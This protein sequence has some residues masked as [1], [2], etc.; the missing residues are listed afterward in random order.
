ML[1]SSA[2]RSA[3]LVMLAMV[4]PVPGVLAGDILRGG[5]T[6]G[7]AAQRA[8][9]EA[10]NRA[11]DAA[12]AAV[13]QRANDRLA[14]TTR[15]ITVMEGAQTAARAA[16]TV[17]SS[18][19]PDGLAEGGLKVLTGPHAR[20]TGANAPVQ[21]ASDE[22]VTVN[23]E[24]TL[25]QAILHWETFNVGRRTLLNFDQSKGGADA[26][27]WTVLNKVF[28]PKGRVTEIYGRIQGQGQ[29]HM[30]NRTGF[31]FRPGSGVEAR[32]I[33][34]SSLP[35]NGRLVERGLV[36]QDPKSVQFL[37]SEL[38][39]DAFDRDLDLI[40]DGQIIEGTDYLASIPSGDVTIEAG[41]RLA[42]RT[43]A[44]KV[45]GRVTLVGANVR[46]SGTIATPDGQTI[47]A[48]G[49]QVG[50][51]A[52]PTTDPTLRGLDVYIG[53]AD[54]TVG[55]A[56][57]EGMIEA[58]RANVTMAGRK[59]R[60]LGVI[61]SSTTTALNGR[62]DLL[63][64][65]NA[66]PY[67]EA[68]GSDFPSDQATTTPLFYSGQSGL[69]EI[70]A[71]SLIAILPE[72]GGTDRA[73][74]T[75]LALGS[76]VNMQ[77]RAIHLGRGSVIHAS[78][79]SLPSGKTMAVDGSRDVGSSS[80]LAGVTA[81][82]GN[83][84][85]TA[86]EKTRWAN[87]D[88]E[89][90]SAEQNYVGG[91]IFFDKGS[92][93]DVAGSVDVHVPLS[94]LLLN[95]QLRG[96]ELANAPL[97]RDGALRGT[98]ITV[99]L[100]R[101]GVFNG[102]F[103]LGTPL[104]D[105]AGYAAIIERNVGQLTVAGGSVGL[106][107]GEAV[108]IQKGSLID[109][110]GG[111][112]QVA[113]GKVALTRLLS[114]G[115][116]VDIGDA[117]P[118]RVYEGIYT[119]LTTAVSTKWGVSKTYRNALAPTGEYYQRPYVEGGDAG[120]I[121]ITAAS[122]ALDGEFK[123]QAVQGHR[124][125][126]PSERAFGTTAAI[127]RGGSLTIN[128]RNETLFSD[129]LVPQSPTP[130]TIVL[131]TKSALPA[132]EDF[133]FDD[134]GVV[135]PLA[136]ERK[137]RLILSPDILGNSGFASLAVDNSDGDI[138]VPVGSA[139]TTAPLG[140]I[141]LS[142]ANITIGASITAPGGDL[143][144]TVHNFSPHE[145][146]KL[147]GTGLEPPTPEPD[148]ERGTFNLA[149]GTVLSTAG[150]I[151]DRRPGF[152]PFRILDPSIPNGGSISINAY[153]ARLM[154]GSVIDASGG[155]TVNSSG[156][157]FYGS[158]GNI[159]IAAGRD[160]SMTWLLGG[161][162]TLLSTL[163]SY[164][165]GRLAGI[166]AGGNAIFPGENRFR[167]YM[168]GFRWEAKGGSLSITAPMIQIGGKRPEGLK[169][170]EHLQLA[171][172]FF[173]KGGF[174]SYSLTGLG[175]PIDAG[176]N[177]FRPGIV[178]SSGTVLEPRAESWRA[179]IS[180]GRTSLQPFRRDEVS[181]VPVSISFNSPVIRDRWDPS[182]PLLS[183]GD[184]TMGA[185]AR[186]ENQ[187]TASVGFSGGTVA[188]LGSVIAPGGSISVRG[189]DSF[190]L[191]SQSDLTAALP[192]VN[193][194]PHSLLSAAGT[195]MRLPDPFGRR[196]GVVLP[197]G[198]ITVAGNVVAEA[199]AVLDVSGASD[200]V[201][202]HPWLL[203]KN[204]LAFGGMA[205]RVPASSGLTTQ[206]FFTT[207]EAVR[208]DSDA[209][210]IAL[211]GSQE[212][213][214]DANLRGFAGGPTA[215]G[216]TLVVSSGRFV[217]V[218]SGASASPL[219]INLIVTETGR[220][221]PEGFYPDGQTAIGNIVPT[222]DGT[223]DLGRGRFAIA[224]FRRGGF[225]ALK[226]CGT[227]QGAVAF[228][229]EISVSA[230]RS[231]DIAEG[232]VLFADSI[233]R[234]SAPYVSLGSVFQTPAQIA[235]AEA[236]SLSLPGN[237]Y[238]TPTSGSGELVVKAA[239]IDIGNLS[240]QGISTASFFAPGGDIRGNGS[241]NVAGTINLA[242]GQIYPTSANIFTIA[243]YDPE[244][245]PDGGTINIAAA[246]KSAPP[247]SAGGKLNLFA[248]NIVQGGT[249]QAPFGT[250]HLGWDGTGP[251]PKDYLSGAGL[252]EGFS[253]PIT[254][255]LTL[256]PE[257]VTSVS[258]KGLVV[259]YGFS[260]DGSSWIDPTGV[261][262][263]ATGPPV[264]A[265][266]L[267]SLN[268]NLQQGSLVDVSGGGEL[269][270]YRWVQG[271]DGAHDLLGSPTADWS[272]STSYE[273]GQ[274][275]LHEGAIWSARRPNQGA[276]PSISLDWT[277]LPGGFAVLPSYSANVAP[278]ASFNNRT[279]ELNLAR[280]EPGY[281]SRGL[282]V[283]DRVYLS[284]G[285]GLA[286]GFYTLLPTRYALLPGG[287]FV[288]PRQTSLAGSIVT[289]EG[290]G[291]VSGYRFNGYPRAQAPA[292]FEKFE[293]VP[294]NTLDKRVRYDDFLASDFFAGSASR[295]GVT[296]PRLPQD[297]GR[298]LVSG[299]DSLELRGFIQGRGAAG[300]YGAEID[301]NSLMPI[302]VV[303]RN[304]SAAHGSVRLDG[305]LISSFGANSIL[306]GGTRE[307]TASGVRV[308]VNTPELSVE[309]G[310]LLKAPEVMLAAKGGLMLGEQV[311]IVQGGRVFGSA[312]GQRRPIL[313]GDETV[314]GSGNG[315]LLAVS[316]RQVA[317][318]R[319][320]VSSQAEQAGAVNAAQL[321]IG[322]GTRL[323]STAL[324][325]DSTH[326][327]RVDPS[328]DV[329]AQEV[330]LQAGSISLALDNPG[331]VPV[332]A[333]LM[334]DKTSLS[335]LQ[336]SGSITLLSYSSID[337][338]GSGLF[339][340][341]GSLALDAASIRG[342]NTG[343]GT[344]A[345]SAEEIVLRNTVGKKNTPTGAT[346][347]QLSFDASSLRLG[348]GDMSIENFARVVM[349]GGQ[350]LVAT[351]SGTLDI[352]GAISVV[353]P[354]VSVSS[355]SF[356]IKASGPAD[357]ARPPA[358]ASGTF[359]TGL[360]A[361]L[362]ITAESLAINTDIILPGGSVA[363]RATSGGVDFAN[364]S[365]ASI[366]V[367]G[368]ERILG[369][370]ARYADGGSVSLTADEGN[371]SIGPS[372]R[373]NVSAA[374]R[375]GNAGTVSI[376][377]PKGTLALGGV[378]SGQSG[379]G[380]RGGS[381]V[382]DVAEEKDITLIDLAL[383]NGGFNQ[384]RSYRIRNGDVAITG[385]AIAHSYSLFA[386]RGSV[387]IT[388]GGM[389][390]SAGRTG[391]SIRIGAGGSI[392]LENGSR[393]SARAD[394][395]DSAGKGGSISLEA[396]SQVGGL[397]DPN[398]KIEIQD[399]SSVDL[400]VA[401]LLAEPPAPGNFSGTLRLRA[402]YLG[403]TG[404]GVSPLRGSIT[405][406]S[407]VI[408]EGYSL[409]DI[410]AD[411]ILNQ[412]LLAA[413]K[414]TGDAFAA[415]LAASS[416]TF[417]GGLP[418]GSVLAFVPGVEIINRTGN[419][420]LGDANSTSASD[421]NLGS[422][423]FGPDSVPGNLTIRAAGDI[424]FFNS[425]SDG[426]T[427]GAHTAELLPRNPKLPDNLQSWSY[428][429][430]AGSDLQAADSRAIRSLDKL[431]LPDTGSIMI[432]K[433]YTENNG[434]PYAGNGLEARTSDLVGETYF[435]TIRTGSGN[436]DLA[437]GRDV[438]LLNQWATVYTAG[439]RIS[440]PTIGGRFE[441]PPVVSIGSDDGPLG[442]QQQDP[443]YA[444]QYSL[445]GGNVSILAQG[446]IKRQTMSGG[447]LVAD[448]QKQ[449][450]NNWLY[451]R[452]YID[453][454]TGS[455]GI[456]R[457][458][459][460]GS[461]TWWVDFSNFFQGVGALGGGNVLLA[462]GNDIANIDAV[463][464]TSGRVTYITESGDRTP[465]RQTLVET[466]GG[467]ITVRAGRDIDAGIYYVERG[468]GLL[469]AGR[470]I[471]TNPTRTAYGSLGF[472][473]DLGIAATSEQ[474]LPT[475]LFV[476]KGGFDVIAGGNLTL[477]PAVNA[478]LL[479][480][481]I[482][483]SFFRKT[484]F[485]SYSPDSYVRATSLGGDVTLRQNS[486]TTAFAEDVSIL[487]NWMEAIHQVTTSDALSLGQPWLRLGETL[488][489][490]FSGMLGLAPPTME[491]SSL[492]GD[493]NLA[494]RFTLSP[495][496]SGTVE[497]LAA[498]AVNGF[499]PRGS[500]VSEVS[501]DSA[502]TLWGNAWINLSDADPDSIPGILRPFAYQ[503]LF[504]TEPANVIE[505]A[506]G[507]LG[508]L[509]ELFL[510]SGSSE[511]IQASIQT[512]QKLHGRSLLHAASTEPMRIFAGSGDISGL[513]L[514]SPKAVQIK[515]GRDITDIAFYIQ[516]TK[517]ADTS[518]VSAKRDIVP[519]SPNS[520]ARTAA[521]AANGLVS[522]KSLDGDIQISGPGSLLVQAGG[523]LD[524]GT[525]AN[526]ADGTG[527][528]ITSVGNARNPNLP[529]KGA[530]LYLGAGLGVSEPDYKT[531][532]E[533]FVRGGEGQKY[534]AELAD[535]TGGEKFEDLD[536][537]KQRLVALQVFYLILRDAGREEQMGQG[538]TKGFEA[539][540]AL[541]PGANYSGDMLTRSRDVRTKSGGN[542]SI[543]VSGGGL[544][545]AT[546]TVGVPVLPP[547]IV[548]EAGGNI[549]IFANGNVDIGISRIFTL[550]GGNQ[551]IWSSAGDIAAGASSKTVQSAPPTRVLID[552]QT[553]ELKVDLGGLATGGG[554]G[555]LASVEGVEPG[556][557]D[558]IAPAGVVDA[559]DAGIRATGNL[560]IAATQ[561]LNADNISVGGSAAGVSTAPIVA[562]PN[563]SGLTA[564]ATA[565][566]ANNSAAQNMANQAD[567][568]ADH[569]GAP[570]IITVEVLGY[571][572]PSDRS[573][574]EDDEEVVGDRRSAS[575]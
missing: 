332:I 8:Q 422:L 117:T 412:S 346:A 497:L 303:P 93:V 126:R 245:S 72:L 305:D 462:A 220:F 153:T 139:L 30:I 295:L 115:N 194:G 96:A 555:V 310:A 510:E 275:A 244:D 82:A 463:A 258:G 31:V 159:S 503:A 472:G 288:S 494:G 358:P 429:V 413:I 359:A 448:S 109:V 488:L 511:G 119:G 83:W 216:G 449:I 70:G 571:G 447:V 536:L 121:V 361:K 438:Q 101:S 58:P 397:I 7:A 306:I 373:I 32:S 327:M 41:A 237:V 145:F 325:L 365:A 424:V 281:T 3:L 128:L 344:F 238:V 469:Q 61:A 339:S 250:I 556:S 59:V 73:I 243:A 336:R 318:V 567:P 308:Q 286:A 400:S 28:D 214:V 198:S 402:P 562:T 149:T 566:A 458:G 453:P 309:S 393:L 480:I 557:V 37:F 431:S 168:N 320:G 269:Y 477:G 111:T 374:P 498:R 75:K 253:L 363:L 206:P 43:S 433:I 17:R 527:V 108:I 376:I 227:A 219:D 2:P 146:N 542:I 546:T 38:E 541:F 99:D 317:V 524:L 123:G 120:S 35:I 473:T 271:N 390:D 516:N 10:R 179:V 478:F 249:L 66:K 89:L 209:G 9:A 366:E 570:S 474:W 299:L 260:T 190:P 484:Y 276:R 394:R 341:A 534:L 523:N 385:P 122:L 415:N 107:A 468:R 504:G 398:A 196:A 263:T 197:G 549:G 213:F 403:G 568:T 457:D 268:L 221:L 85:K 19:I 475:T 489:R 151:T 533:R 215:Q 279:S 105:V 229:G 158:G 435:Q 368:L 292:L 134:I 239:H 479:P 97:Q 506:E 137:S 141:S 379:E 495:S 165:G 208:V 182:N 439:T 204:I 187:P 13:R 90:D 177:E 142:G 496:P 241:L 270:A 102:Q 350:G 324:L 138:V 486:T 144:F 559:G 526:N 416:A 180:G 49:R 452:G 371:I 538:Y 232:G 116:L 531:F 420:V 460:I 539:I 537:A 454:E 106:A 360:G 86:G 417:S 217:D 343:E 369:D 57:N 161:K 337:L 156:R 331:N 133:S 335:G 574:T 23:I 100:R 301:I 411:G 176:A 63:A 104:G 112:R 392:L 388:D 164:S 551:I 91:Q 222:P 414:T 183:R 550:R 103:W 321:S 259:P 48:A 74:G 282:A 426:F 501:G 54:D 185:G 155:L 14:A 181:S 18:Q 575:L 375:G 351:G 201:D 87:S 304:S 56:V 26:G 6:S 4:F 459:E 300:G 386:D 362:S 290:T 409:F 455:F 307:N 442:V 78:G 231:L 46:N 113:G 36:N 569:G 254:R 242:A 444:A 445:A 436:I 470:D 95:L 186:I 521:S 348:G 395:F 98:P 12:A 170:D 485:S 69:V 228:E 313:I 440:D 147:N 513:T 110:A 212:L 125:L 370:V 437:A 175:G 80:L 345:F 192:T 287:V 349:R 284:A 224:S 493:V 22:N 483:N 518:F 391:G 94:Q 466:G 285:P 425:L 367:G 47:I 44:E 372:G 322:R 430:T 383:N 540:A 302:S 319:S 382:L 548:T 55:E 278:F 234:L 79:A 33:V 572:G 545:L 505:T 68:E 507:F 25:Q 314:A 421:W 77:G 45:G 481:G 40:N 467:D 553:G 174:S 257:S 491:A 272:A 256:A 573:P 543:F 124:Q 193:L 428:R 561:V 81:R 528:G 405:A 173:T 150:L 118:D 255:S 184:I 84:I 399:G 401:Q 544:S 423:R 456:T 230:R 450:P 560:S 188:I 1:R 427:S 130:P 136:E 547:G 62:V 514:F 246:G 191:Y 289:P 34:V 135:G 143:K 157:R 140:S 265:V 326:G 64:N 364:L 200:V 211:L 355:G 377:A 530:D 16:A 396:G 525:G 247:L 465:A 407:T 67:T 235:T 552:P 338:Y 264:K 347:G 311:S 323:S 508:P 554:I 406:A 330:S 203:T 225:D 418:A 294:G 515:A 509:D 92:V 207:A 499:Q 434:F 381:F 329:F 195:L 500:V 167:G 297:A 356:A 564:G 178:I 328:V 127:A 532:I 42:A 522:P 199:G 333:G 384:S 5:M 27:K 154:Q 529:F 487:Q 60:Q 277:R 419:L 65:F 248:A 20:W 563:I 226:L 558:L 51:D 451:R 267:S 404:L 233:V 172:Q 169:A 312:S 129:A 492:S 52:H 274:L 482:N 464:P 29:V 11:A 408:V 446:D 316:D 71:G 296:L 410:T 114:G 163:Q 21:S 251:Q 441:V 152:S 565:N 352:G 88:L 166:G 353:A 378:I 160:P 53:E 387:R 380:G 148:P 189:A 236:E 283:G 15:V 24:Q 202:V 476:G 132:V 39:R 280:T 340:S 432:G 210:R 461:T 240:L 273:A 252:T 520:A 298:V 131:N 519:S 205:P 315:T 443:T 266:N 334:L 291:I 50:F 261:D 502:R 357:F 171:P 490:P 223:D 354:S 517:T 76:I 293:I 162:L 535:L 471:I 512:K 262:I 342:F 389:I 218:N